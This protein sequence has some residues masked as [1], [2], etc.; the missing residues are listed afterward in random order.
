MRLPREC[1]TEG[2]DKRLEGNT[3]AFDFNEDGQLTTLRGRG[4]VKLILTPTR[5]RRR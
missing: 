1:G 2:Y 5:P 4:G 3:L